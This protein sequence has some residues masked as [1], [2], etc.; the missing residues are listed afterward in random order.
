MLLEGLDR[1][2]PQ[3]NGSDEL[4]ETLT[5]IFSLRSQEGESLKTW[6]SRATEAFDKCAR[7]TSVSFPEEA[8]GWIVLRKSGLSEEQKAVSLPRSLGVL[9]REE[10]GR[11]MRFCYPEYVV[12][13]KRSYG[14]SLVEDEPDAPFSLEGESLEEPSRMW[15]SFWQTMR[16]R[17]TTK[18]TLNQ[19]PLKR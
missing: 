12:P 10:I 2:F 4:S 18:F 9:K 8:R 1:R 13:K 15:N 6:I 17:Q 3:K 16:S 19:K 5:E 11:A 7:K 14:V